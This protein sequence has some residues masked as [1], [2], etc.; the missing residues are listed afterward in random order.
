MDYEKQAKDFLEATNTTLEIKK[1]EFQEAPEW[2]TN[3][4]YGIKYFVQLKNAKGSF[5]FPFW[6][7]IS[8]KEKFEHLVAG[9]KRPSAYSILSA[10]S[11]YE[12]EQDYYEFC[13]EF[14]YEPSHSSE[15]VHKAV[16]KEWENLNKIFTPEELG[17]L[18]EIQ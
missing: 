15:R 11:G 12:P 16:L 17:Q 14:G 1:A 6:D 13:K 4:N 5:V 18:S 7:S 2:A 9:G 3:G 8:N 10:L